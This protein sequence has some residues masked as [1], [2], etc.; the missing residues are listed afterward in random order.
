MHPTES[1]TIKLSDGVERE[2][3]F[4]MGSLR[5]LKK[6]LKA[7]TTVEVLKRIDADTIPDFIFEGLVD[8]KGIA[9][10]EQVAD[11]MDVRDLQAL[12]ND[13]TSS[14]TTSFPESTPGET[15]NDLSSQPVN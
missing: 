1:V 11:L 7:N 15:K 10:A 3:R 2:L 8:K 5:R 4:S 9:D 12:T 14:L 6:T 13:L